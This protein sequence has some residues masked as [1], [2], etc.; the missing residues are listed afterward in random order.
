[1]LEKKFLYKMSLIDPKTMEILYNYTNIEMLKLESKSKDISGIKAMEKADNIRKYSSLI[2]ELD[3][4][5]K[6]IINT[7]RLQKNRLSKVQIEEFNLELNYIK[8]KV[9]VAD[10]EV[11][12]KAVEDVKMEINNADNWFEAVIKD[13]GKAINYIILPSS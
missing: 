2:V 13:A 6:N 10:K 7:V 8:S 5:K 12:T 9:E 1:M 3:N 11:I 4:L